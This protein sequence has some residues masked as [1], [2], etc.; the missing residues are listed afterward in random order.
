[1]YKMDII[2][3]FTIFKIMIITTIRISQ[4]V[5]SSILHRLYVLCV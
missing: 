5:K 3:H 4:N 1:M 2:K